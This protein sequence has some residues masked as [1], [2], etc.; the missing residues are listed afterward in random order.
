VAARAYARPYRITHRDK[1][2]AYQREWRSRKYV[3]SGGTIHGSERS[4]AM[5]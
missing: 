2:V 3:T 1:L 5:K 4:I